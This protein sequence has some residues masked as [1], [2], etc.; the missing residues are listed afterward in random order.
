VIIGKA[1]GIL[2]RRAQITLA[3]AVLPHAPATRVREIRGGGCGER[4]VCV[5]VLRWMDDLGVGYSAAPY[6]EERHKGT[7][8]GR[9]GRR[10]VE[11]EAT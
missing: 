3:S 10:P 1:A 5:G 11:G 2:I 8:G 9:I 7:A 6:I 4:Q